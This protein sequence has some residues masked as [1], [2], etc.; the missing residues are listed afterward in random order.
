MSTKHTLA[1]LSTVWLWGGINVNNLHS[2]SQCQSHTSQ[3]VRLWV[4]P[5]WC[6]SALSFCFHP[7]KISLFFT[8]N[9]QRSYLVKW[10][11][12]VTRIYSIMI[13]PEP[14]GYTLFYS[15]ANCGYYWMFND[16]QKLSCQ[17]QLKN[18]RKYASH[19]IYSLHFGFA[20]AMQQPTAVCGWYQRPRPASRPAGKLLV[21]SCLL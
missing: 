6:V 1:V 10:W 12:A 5:A 15:H 13:N 17:V 16:W 19:V 8:L 2:K 9:I 3:W 11:E 7:L 21:C 4:E 18:Y 14:R 20:G